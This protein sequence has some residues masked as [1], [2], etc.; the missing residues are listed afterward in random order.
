MNDHGRLRRPVTEAWAAG[1]MQLLLYPLA[2]VYAPTADDA[3]AFAD[4][5]GLRGPGARQIA[6]Q[7]EA[8]A[9][10]GSQDE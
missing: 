3:E 6:A 9:W 2:A 5:H 10:G 7:M 4:A 8:R 1:E